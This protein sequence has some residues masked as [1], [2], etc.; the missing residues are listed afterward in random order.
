MDPESKATKLTPDVY[1][2]AMNKS[3]GTIGDIASK[4]KVPLTNELRNNFGQQILEANRDR[5]PDVARIVANQVDDLISK[6]DNGVID[7]TAFRN[8]NTRI[9]KLIRESKDGDLQAAL[10][11]IQD[12]A[13]NSFESS[14]APDKLPLWKEARKRYAVGMQILP[15]SAKTTIGDLKPTDVMRVVTSGKDA[16]RRM[17]YTGGGD[18]GDLAKGGQEFMKEPSFGSLP[19]RIAT[20]GLLGGLGSGVLGGA[21]AAAAGATYGASTLYNLLG[22]S[23]SRSIVRNQQ[24]LLGGSKSIPVGAASVLTPTADEFSSL[25]GNKNIANNGSGERGVPMPASQEGI[26]AFAGMKAK[27][28]GI[29]LGDKYGNA[30]PLNTVDARDHVPRAGEI[31]VQKGIG[32]DAYTE[33]ARG[34]GVTDSMVARFISKL[35]EQDK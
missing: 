5:V 16:Q 13:M 33:L 27:D 17:A 34:Q 20:Y 23:I 31:V 29:T 18:L 25:F 35:K 21:P 8:W 14:I 22:P 9:G 6:A 11:G 2:D 32:K 1:S 26:N 30:R 15:L 12:V 4:T 10:G 19:E 7:G 24:G 3:G 28:Q